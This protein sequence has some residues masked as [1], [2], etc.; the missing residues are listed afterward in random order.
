MLNIK[1]PYNDSDVRTSDLADSIL[2]MV[3]L[4]LDP[5]DVDLEGVSI[6]GGQTDRAGHYHFSVAVPPLKEPMF[7]TDGDIAYAMS[8]LATDLF[9]HRKI[10]LHFDWATAASSEDIAA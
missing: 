5:H 4:V 1:W 9:L 3:H 7:T 2:Y 6:T 8:S 10:V